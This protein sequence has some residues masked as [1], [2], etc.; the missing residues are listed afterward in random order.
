MCQKFFLCRAYSQDML[1]ELTNFMPLVSFDTP[2]KHQETI[3][4]YLMSVLLA[5]LGSAVVFL[6]FHYFHI[7]C[8]KAIKIINIQNFTRRGCLYLS[9]YNMV[10]RNC[11]HNYN[12]IVSKY[13]KI[14]TRKTFVYRHFWNSDHRYRFKVQDPRY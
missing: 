11:H 7:R 12:A 8:T 14:R 6:L 9:I 1:N 13:G 4:S 10:K 2:W 5:S 3:F